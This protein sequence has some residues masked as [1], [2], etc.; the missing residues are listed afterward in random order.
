MVYETRV[1]NNYANVMKEKVECRR[2]ITAR[3]CNLSFISL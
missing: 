3:D 1:L 2:R